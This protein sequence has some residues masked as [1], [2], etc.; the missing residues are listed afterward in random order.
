[1]TKNCRDRALASSIVL[2]TADLLRRQFHGW[3]HSVISVFLASV[4]KQ[5]RDI[6]CEPLPFSVTT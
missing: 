3:I 1:M 4:A 5:R 6:A 2:D